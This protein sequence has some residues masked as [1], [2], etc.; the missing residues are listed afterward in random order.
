MKKRLHSW[1]NHLPTAQI[2][3][4]HAAEL[5]ALIVVAVQLAA[6]LSVEVIAC[7]LLRALDDDDPFPLHLPEM[8]VLPSGNGRA[9]QANGP[10]LRSNEF[11]QNPQTSGTPLRVR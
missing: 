3:A 2:D 1:R 11:S 4:A 7:R 10:A 5:A 8:E 6:A 9:H